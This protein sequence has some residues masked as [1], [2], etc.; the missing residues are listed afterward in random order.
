MD[1]TMSASTAQGVNPPD[2]NNSASFKSGESFNTKSHHSLLRSSSS[3]HGSA[4]A[5]DADDGW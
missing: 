2:A 5:E 4:R 3:T 1:A